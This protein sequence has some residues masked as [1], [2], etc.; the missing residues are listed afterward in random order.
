FR[1]AATGDKLAAR[2][3]DEACAYLGLACVNIC[4][5]LD[6]DTILLAGGMAQAE[7]LVE[8]VQAEFATRGWNILPHECQIETAS[9]CAPGSSGLVGAGGC[10]AAEYARQVRREMR[11]SRSS[12]EGSDRRSSGPTGG[13][14]NGGSSDGGSGEQGQGFEPREDSGD[15]EG[16]VQANLQG[17]GVQLQEDSRDVE[18]DVQESFQ[19]QRAQP[20]E[21]FSAVKEDVRKNGK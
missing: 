12:R 4:R 15:V 16:D 20:H 11:R 8:K 19:G 17:Q 14:G 6:P 3:V 5:M 7:G 2:V 10:A 1:L 21:D 18:G 9:V 13:C